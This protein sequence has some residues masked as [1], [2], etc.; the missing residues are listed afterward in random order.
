MNITKGGDGI[1]GFSKV[2]KALQYYALWFIFGK[3]SAD[4]RA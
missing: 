3:K 4:R 1:T 2:V